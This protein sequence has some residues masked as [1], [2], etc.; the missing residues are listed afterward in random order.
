MNAF[1][2]ASAGLLALLSPCVS[3]STVTNLGR[4][5]DR[6]HHLFPPPPPFTTTSSHHLSGTGIFVSSVAADSPSSRAGLRIGDEVLSAN[7]LSFQGITHARAVEIIKNTTLLRMVVR[8]SAK[9]ETGCMILTCAA[10]QK[11]VL[12]IGAREKPREKPREGRGIRALASTI[13]T[14]MPHQH[15]HHHNHV[16]GCSIRAMFR[17]STWR[18]Q[19]ST[20]WTQRCGMH[21]LTDR[22]THTDRRT[23]RYTHTHTLSLSL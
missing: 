8:V 21:P 13:A 22:H 5:T 2:S 4:L 15:Q 11:G 17:P 18:G 19:L 10:R 3:L 16:I 23:G 12:L 14:A 20:G 6:S 9:E 1:P 7:G